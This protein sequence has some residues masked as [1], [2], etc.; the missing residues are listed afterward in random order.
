MNTVSWLR[1]WNEPIPFLFFIVIVVHD[2][3][4]FLFVDESVDDEQNMD[5]YS[6]GDDPYSIRILCSL[7]FDFDMGKRVNC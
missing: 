7:E 6:C 2:I 3:V 1:I 5:C 4:L